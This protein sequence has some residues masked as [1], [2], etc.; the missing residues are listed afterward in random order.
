M[1][2]PLS[3]LLLFQK[4]DFI[5]ILRFNNRFMK[6][7]IL[8]WTTVLYGLL[9]SLS[10]VYIGSIFGRW[11]ANP[12]ATFLIFPIFYLAL[13][14]YS[15]YMLKKGGSVAAYNCMAVVTIAFISII[16]A[17]WVVASANGMITTA[18]IW[19]IWVYPAICFVVSAGI[20][21]LF[22]VCAWKSKSKDH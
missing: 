17:I 3:L 12:D 7:T 20:T 9:Y 18:T 15:H 6:K 5:V 19:D 21:V 13:F 14:V 1:V 4:F 10:L 2:M 11:P 22:F 16:W 8:T